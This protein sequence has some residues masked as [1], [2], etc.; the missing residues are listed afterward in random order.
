MDCKCSGAN[1]CT[2]SGI[3]E[4]VVADFCGGC[5][6]KFTELF[7]AIPVNSCGAQCGTVSSTLFICTIPGWEMKVAVTS[8]SACPLNHHLAGIG[9]NP[10][11]NG[12]NRQICVAD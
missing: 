12:K 10:D 8:N 1:G 3:C 5:T 4:Q 7:A 11:C 9:V 2:T 6:G